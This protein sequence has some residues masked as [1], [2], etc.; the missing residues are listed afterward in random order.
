M[1]LINQIEAGIKELDGGKFQ[2]LGDQYL[3]KKY[4]FSKIIALGSQE[5]TDKTTPGVPDTYFENNGKGVYVMYGTH[6]NAFKKLKEDILSVKEMLA[7]TERECGKVD[8]IICCHTSSN[9]GLKK[10]E[11]LE[12]LAQPYSLELVG[13]NEIASDL[14]KL[15][16][17][18]LA[19]EYLGISESTEQ[20]WSIEDFIKIHD[21]SR[22]NAPISNSYIGNISTKLINELKSTQVLLIVAKPG[23]GKTR[24]AIE[25][26][27]EFDRNQYNVLCIKSN[28]QPVYTDIKKYLESGKE[29]II[30]IDDI[31]VVE[32]YKSVL[33]LAN[34]SKNIKFIITV[35]DYAAREINSTIKNYDHKSIFPDKFEK[36][37][38]EQLTQ[39]FVD[40][41][42][43]DVVVDHIVKISNNNPRMAV[44][45][46]KLY[47][48]DSDRNFNDIVDV[49]KDY[50]SEILETNS[51]TQVEEKV[52]FILSYL[53]KINLHDLSQNEEL[54]QLMKILNLTQDQLLLGVK[55]LE[56]KELCGTY[57][58][59]LVRIEDQSLDDYIV[60]K[61]LED[62][63][64]SVSS[65]L[66]NLYPLNSEKV[67][68][69]LNQFVSFSFSEKIYQSLKN[70]VQD[71]Y[72]YNKFENSTE[73]ENFLTQFGALISAEAYI[74]LKDKL[75]KYPSKE[76][77]VSDFMDKRDKG[78]S[79]DT[80]VF[81]IIRTLSNS[82]D[83][84]PNLAFELLLKYFQKD[85]NMISEVYTIIKN[86]FSTV[87][88][89][90]PTDYNQ[91]KYVI[92]EL[93]KLDL[94]ERYNQE[95]LVLIVE[96]FLEVRDKYMYSDGDKVT[97]V[98]FEIPES[99]FLIEYH[100]Q[101]LNLLAEIYFLGREDIRAYIQKILLNYQYKITENI[102]S[103]PN[104][105]KEDLE[106]IKTLFFREFPNLSMEEERIIY[107]LNKMAKKVGLSVFNGYKVTER[108]KLYSI[109]TTDKFRYIYAGDESKQELKEIANKYRNSM[110][111]VFRYANQFKQNEQMNS[112][113]IEDV[114][115]NIFRLLDKDSRYKFLE[116][117]FSKKYRFES[118]IPDEFIN[119]LD[120]D[121]VSDVL[122]NI[123]QE[124]R[125]RWKIAALLTLNDVT[126]SDLETLKDILS[127]HNIPEY[128][129]I[130][131][132]EKFILMDNSLK[133]FLIQKN[134][135][136]NFIIPK[137][138]RKEET[139]KLMTLLGDEYLKKL[140][141]ENFGKN[142]D[143]A[144]DLVY[145]LG[146]NDIEF[147]FEILKKLNDIKLTQRNL[148]NHI[149]YNIEKFSNKSV[150]YQKYFQF[151][152]EKENCGYYNS[153]LEDI[154]D[155]A[156]EIIELKLQNE[157][158]EVQ[159]IKILNWGLEKL[160][161]NDI[162]L[163]LFKIFKD[164]GFGKNTYQQIHFI[165]WYRSWCGSFV[166]VLE[167]EK[168]FLNE[169][170]EIF[171][172]DGGYINLVLYIEEKIRGQNL[173]I[174]KER[175][176]E[177]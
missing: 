28:G 117:M 102:D 4:H 122:K 170:K 101:L 81:S 3:I 105:V 38:M 6:K 79:I 168:I 8:R 52:L 26:C 23:T 136:V 143:S 71:F 61:F 59:K 56:I 92:D 36:E 25:I 22:T 157:V 85:P 16:F 119:F 68:E 163:T 146:K 72:K 129:S 155:D 121:R 171:E 142:I 37:Q 48:K 42:I 151:I 120:K 140:Y 39:Q 97:I 73:E 106:A 70:D 91:V 115:Y 162:K 113:C 110:D 21:S 50:Y 128:Y 165:K 30:F 125:Y 108:Q 11:R 153:L 69:L 49:L 133:E 134:S 67:I 7:S 74:Y 20:V 167:E 51:V 32:D 90:K 93:L 57:N 5:G 174:E 154:I 126:I 166:P 66:N 80:S 164:K 65:L 169:V 15:E 77:N 94:E 12:K 103:Y 177:F 114:L 131:D 53:E 58:N 13:I 89:G 99:D 111:K 54:Q 17:Q 41:K 9:I 76:Y 127:K 19:K 173:A 44:L 34:S 10:R 144:A 24:L 124:E 147:S 14:A 132:F 96:K 156:P 47:T 31:N 161:D 63:R 138:V 152:L 64:V 29:N 159:A 82:G 176:E 2:G 1:G 149:L 158:D 60:V 95:I 75:K 43:N 130:V 137:I 148:S 88:E 45:A 175:E 141:L 116:A 109:L 33:T 83:S 172:K 55:E 160:K 145:E 104:M 46:T 87:V 40:S 150:L 86:N 27:K 35:R 98:N 123:D 118:I 62:N 84:Y 135:D 139:K 100:G 107:Q 18:F 112:S 78:E